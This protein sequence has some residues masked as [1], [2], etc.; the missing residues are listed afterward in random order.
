MSSTKTSRLG[1]VI[2]F[3]LSGLFIATAVFLFVNRQTVLDQLAVWTYEPAQQVQNI[4]ERVK[5]TPKGQFVFYATH[6]SLESQE[7]F[8]KECPRQETGSPILGC[9]TTADR[10][11]I[12]D[13]T[14]E[15]LDGMEEVTA[16]HEMLHAVWHRTGETERKELEKE[17]RSAYAKLETGNIKE[18]MDYYERTEPGELVNELH[19]ILGT[20]TDSLSPKLEKYYRQFFERTAVLALHKK[21]S[22]VY[23]ALY[24]RADELYSSMDALGRSIDSRN[25]AYEAAV[26]QLS[27]DINSFNARA[28]NGSFSSQSQFNSERAALVRRTALLEA[29]REA[30][31][32]D[33]QVYNGYYEEYQKIASQIEG[34]NNSV[35]SYKQIEQGPSV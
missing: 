6:P 13:L 7:G 34:L 9:Y 1:S 15:Q 33:I 27:A 26:R 12:Y 31:N 32:T 18:R 4:S 5:F 20:E 35:D 24:A 29:D 19:S 16:V 2:A 10:I 30:I 25:K 8:N 21:Y 3:A 22:T 23:E 17:L 28:N 11:Y 14:D